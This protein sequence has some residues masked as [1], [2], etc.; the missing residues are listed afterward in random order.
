MEKKRR[1]GV[2]VDYADAHLMEFKTEIIELNIIESTFTQQEKI[3][4]ENEHKRKAKEKRKHT[5]FYKDLSETIK[6]Y[7]EVV[8]FGS[9]ESKKE[10]VNILRSDD[11][12]FNIKIEVKDTDNLNEN[13][14]NN[15]VKE[16]FLKN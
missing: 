4:D 7:D 2:W 8:I 1:L 6:Y 14:Q 16:Y 13:Q 12:F 10:L 11:K 9:P 15:F 3:E 5:K